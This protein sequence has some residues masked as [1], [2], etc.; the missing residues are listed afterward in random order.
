MVET[1]KQMPFDWVRHVS[2]HLLDLDQVPLFGTS[3]S[4]PWDAFSSGLG[5][6]FEVDELVI[7]GSSWQWRASDD[8]LTGLG[9]PLTP[10]P[11]S[12]TP[13]AG[14]ASLLIT[15]DQLSS[16]MGW[17]LGQ[18]TD[19]LTLPDHDYRLAFTR[20][21]ALE[22]IEQ[23]GKLEFTSDLIPALKEGEELPQGDAIVQDIT[24]SCKK[25]TASARLI[26]SPELQRAWKEHHSGKLTVHKSPLAP[27][28]DVE[29]GVEVGKT[30]VPRELFKAIN[31]GDFL[32]LDSCWATPGQ[33][34]GRV[35]LTVGGKP[36]FRGMIKEDKLKLLEYPLYE[37]VEPTMDNN[38]FDDDEEEND[39]FDEFEELSDNEESEDEV[40]ETP[41][42]PVEE[43]AE[44]STPT[45][46]AAMPAAEISP[47][48]IPLN[49]SVEVARLKM[50]V[51][52]LCELS[53]GNMLELDARPEQGVTLVSNGHALARGELIQVGDV[54]G[55]RILSVGA[56]KE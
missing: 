27:D 38:N 8:L 29:I 37:E 33:D 24:I 42:E 47:D 22:A 53:P 7:K 26:V 2:R 21:V 50:D 1:T 51:K 6:L 9:E 4:F 43:E 44:E 35:V 49:I 41:E 14:S 28:I 40:E 20:F 45:T 5:S 16:L 56:S 31:T 25:G 13:L 54:L 3:P 55:V 19:I 48:E 36:A 46:S 23:F 30:T 10:I 39:D 32:V 18:E 52:T 17:F 34:K 15:Q 12:V 11:F